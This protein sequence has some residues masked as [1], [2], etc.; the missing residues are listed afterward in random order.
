M[1]FLVWQVF[2]SLVLMCSCVTAEGQSNEAK[3]KLLRR[4]LEQ[5]HLTDSFKIK[6]PIEKQC[7]LVIVDKDNQFSELQMFFQTGYCLF[8]RKEMFVLAVKKYVVIN[9]ITLMK[10]EGLVSLAFVDETIP[11]STKFEFK[12]VKKNGA[13]IMSE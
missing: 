7:S 11:A 3:S 12:F 1:K 5:S 13:W 8:N 6:V 10:N 4:A 2:S 9:Q